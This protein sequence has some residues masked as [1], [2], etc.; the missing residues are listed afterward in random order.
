MRFDEKIKSLVKEAE[1]YRSQGLLNEALDTYK[2]MQVLIEST[3]NV[4][5]KE[6][7]LKKIS[8]KVDALY[9]QMEEELSD[10]KPPEVS[11]DEQDAIE[12]LIPKD[13]PEAKGSPEMAA[14][15][16]LAKTGQFD[17]AIEKFTQLLS[18]DSLRFDAAKNI[19]WCWI[20][21][22]EVEKALGR[23]KQWMVGNVLSL[24]EVNGVRAYFEALVKELGLDAQI[25]T[26]NIQKK[27]EPESEVEDQDILDINSTRFKLLRGSRKGEEVEL[28]ISFQAG[29]YLK[30]LVPKRD[31]QLIESVN[32]GDRF[33]GMQFYS[34]MAIFSGT[35]YVSSK[36]T[37]SAGPKKGDYSLEIKILNIQT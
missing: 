7:L 30:M 20:Q 21:Q 36:V 27:L 10:I 24:D 15:L 29:K 18:Q 12:N 14:A 8:N 11:K 2:K 35:G 33:N 5:N 23:V 13:D 31:R 32:V 19:V 9:H 17:Q 26:V 4:K 3:Q 25:S 22:K 28:E 34:P 37:I 1:L 16:S 6:T